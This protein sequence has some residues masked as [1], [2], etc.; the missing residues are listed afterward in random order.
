MFRNIS[1]CA[2]SGVFQSQADVF[3]KLIID[4]IAAMHERFNGLGGVLP[5][6]AFIRN[7]KLL[8]IP[9]IL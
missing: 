9:Y 1:G 8:C 3:G 6:M 2:I 5:H 7:I 4:S